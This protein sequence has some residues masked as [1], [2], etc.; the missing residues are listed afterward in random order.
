MSYIKYKK[1]TIEEFKSFS[2]ETAKYR[3]LTVPYLTGA[4]VDVAS[5]GATVV[6]WAMSFDLPE[7]E[8]LHYSGGN[9]PKGPIHLR[10]H[11]DHLPFESN[12]LDW[13]YSS[14]LIEDFDDP[15]PYISEWSRV[16]RVGGKLVILVPDKE[17]WNEAIKNG[18]M[19][20]CSHRH[21][22]RVGEL[23]ELFAQYYGH[24]K[25]IEDRLTNLSPG[26]YTIIFAAEK[27]R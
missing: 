19:P 22:Y 7:R 17:L 12:S 18:Q 2:S 8:F 14:H 20:N 10:G 25:V 9:P 11:A 6:P 15:K 26:D 21:E 5:Q 24:F 16:L 1:P 27:L 3:S 4:G 13:V 23:T